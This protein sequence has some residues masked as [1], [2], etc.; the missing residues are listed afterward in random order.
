MAPSHWT[1]EMSASHQAGKDAQKVKDAWAVACETGVQDAKQNGYAGLY[2]DRKNP[3]DFRRMARIL[4]GPRSKYL[5]SLITSFVIC[6]VVSLS[7]ACSVMFTAVV[8][9]AGALLAAVLTFPPPLLPPFGYSLLA[10]P[11]LLCDRC[12]LLT[13]AVGWICAPHAAV[14]TLLAL[15]S[16]SCF[17]FT[18]RR[19]VYNDRNIC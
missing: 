7:W 16:L 10:G 9:P 13:L 14:W 2:L 19:V 5:R 17:C 8:D 6:S 18:Y 12:R 1:D 3:G 11:L 15:L 4:V